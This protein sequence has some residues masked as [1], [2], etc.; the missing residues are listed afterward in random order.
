ML[1]SLPLRSV[2]DQLILTIFPSLK[3]FAM[4][5][6]ATLVVAS[7][8]AVSAFA[9]SA[10]FVRSSTTLNGHF[11]SGYKPVAAVPPPPPASSGV[12]GFSGFGHATGDA[13]PAAAAPPA[14]KPAEPLFSGF[15]HATGPMGGSPNIMAKK[16]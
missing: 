10:T 14:V 7:A 9:P 15:G 12:P 16:N 1:S 3:P 8:T 5:F 11:L 2:E 4:K 13:T 6:T